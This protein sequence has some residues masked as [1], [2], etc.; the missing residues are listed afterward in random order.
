MLYIACSACVAL[1]RPV[2]L[3]SQVHQELLAQLELLA[4]PPAPLSSASAVAHAF[5]CIYPYLRMYATYCAAY[6]AALKAVEVLRAT[7][8]ALA[9]IEASSGER[10]NYLLIKPVQ[11]LCK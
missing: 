9:D 11:R 7:V 1:C 6:P 2:S 4:A 10:L 5:V 8:P 3:P